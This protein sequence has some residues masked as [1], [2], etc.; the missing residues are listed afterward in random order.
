MSDKPWMAWHNMPV[1]KTA[2]KEGLTEAYSRILNPKPHAGLEIGLGWGVSAEHFLM[3][4]HESLLIVIDINPEL[5]ARRVLSER[6]K[7]QFIYVHPSQ[8]MATNIQF[9]WLYIDGSH[10]YEDVKAD[11]NCYHELLRPGGVMAFDDYNTSVNDRWHYPGVKY[12]VDEFLQ[13][14]GF[15]YSPVI[16]PKKSSTGLAFVVKEA[17]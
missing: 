14:Q 10:E 5:E 11:L 2:Y 17:G 12:A 8:C 9:D 4:F 3:H 6:Y 15:L 16:L 13:E 7:E 1:D